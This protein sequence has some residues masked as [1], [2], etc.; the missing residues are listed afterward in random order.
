MSVSIPKDRGKLVLG[1]RPLAVLI[2]DDERLW[3]RCYGP[4]IQRDFGLFSM[5]ARLAGYGGVISARREEKLQAAF[6]GRGSRRRRAG[7]TTTT[8]T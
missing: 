8:D 7:E 5:G 2:F 1:A 3:R 6:A 4:E